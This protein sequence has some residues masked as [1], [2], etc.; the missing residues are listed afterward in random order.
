MRIDASPQLDR[1]ARTAGEPGDPTGRSFE[2]QRQGSFAD[3]RN[4]PIPRP[5]RI[6]R[7]RATTQEATE[8][9]DGLGKE[10]TTV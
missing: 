1:L 8:A 3:Q 5:G 6:D 10:L 2:D 4:L 9:G 7:A